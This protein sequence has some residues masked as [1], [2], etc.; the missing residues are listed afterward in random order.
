MTQVDIDAV[1]VEISGMRVVEG[2]SLRTGSAQVVGLAGPSGSSKST[3]LR[4]FYRALRPPADAVRLGGPGVA[5]RSGILDLYAVTP[6]QRRTAA[7]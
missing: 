6:P 1:T 2:I 4:C 5:P 7:S 3:L